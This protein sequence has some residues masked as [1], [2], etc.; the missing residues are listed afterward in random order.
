LSEQTELESL[1]ATRS[2]LS[3]LE[4]NL[5]M[6]QELRTARDLVQKPSSSKTS[7]TKLSQ[8]LIDRAALRKLGDIVQQILD[9][10][11]F[12]DNG[13]VEFDEQTMDFIVNG[14][15]RVNNGKGVRAL[16]HSAFAIALMRFCKENNL[17][18]PG[19]V[20]L[21]S[22]LTTLRENRQDGISE[23]VSGEIQIAF[24]E[25]L[26]QAP[27]DEQ[28]IILENKVPPK[29]IQD[30]I[31]YYEFWKEGA[32]RKGFFPPLKTKQSQLPHSG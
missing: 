2:A 27:K 7:S 9:R 23:D 16:I 25:D 20:V 14:K 26:A 13:V 24:F 29:Y 4:V 11:R 3:E 10:W 21:D 8:G 1:L 31:K 30:Q 5:L 28:I 6:L 32:V 22:P 12:P 17:P 15:P 18:H 19:I